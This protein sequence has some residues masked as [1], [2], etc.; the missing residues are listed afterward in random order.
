MCQLLVATNRRSRASQRVLTRQASLPWLVLCHPLPVILP[1]LQPWAL[2]VY[3][4]HQVMQAVLA[5]TCTLFG[6]L[7]L[8]AVGRVKRSIAAR[9]AMVQRLAAATEHLP[10]DAVQRVVGALVRLQAHV[11]RRQAVVAVARMVAMDAYEASAPYR[12]HMLWLLNGIVG[13]YLVTC[14]YIIALYGA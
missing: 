4:V 11:R 3:C 2:R 10:E 14:V 13:L 9:R 12:N 7:W 1:A 8:R 6:T 5:A